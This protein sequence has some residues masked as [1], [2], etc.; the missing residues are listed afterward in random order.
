MRLLL[1]KYPFGRHELVIINKKK[2]NGN[3]FKKDGFF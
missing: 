1:S 3:I 2:I